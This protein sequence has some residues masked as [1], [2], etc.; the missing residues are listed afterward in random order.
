M[1]SNIEVQKICLFCGKM[2]TARTT[3]TKYCSDRCSKNA[4]KQ[5]MRE[6]KINKS[7]QEVLNQLNFSDTP[8]TKDRE[9]LSVSETAAELG[10]HRATVY[11]YLA[12]HEIKCLTIRGKTFIR[13]RD[14]DVLF[15]YAKPYQVREQKPRQPITEF[16]TMEEILEKYDY[17][18]GW[19]YQIIKDNNIPKVLHWGRAM[20]SRKHIDKVLSAKIPDQSITEWYTVEDIQQKYHMTNNAIRSFVYEKNIPK[21]RKGKKGYYS[22]NHFDRAKGIE[23]PDTPLYYT[24]EEAMSKYNLTRDSLYYHVKINNVSKIKEGRHIKISK[25]ELDE[26]FEKQPIIY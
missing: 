24:T 4:Y 6:D 2:F 25:A 16:Y 3:V 13:R 20:Y 7:N 10:I 18:K 23:V 11:R 9:Y 17:G 14:I 5:R 1:S 15:E 8:I 22:K 26:V 12:A 19:I 21:T